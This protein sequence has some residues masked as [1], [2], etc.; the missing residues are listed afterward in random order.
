MA[1]EE[2]TITQIL[3]E[4]GI[5]L[6]VMADASHPDHLSQRQKLILALQEGE[7]TKKRVEAFKEAFPFAMDAFK[8]VASHASEAQ[9]QT[10]HR[11]H[12]VCGP[13]A[14][15]SLCSV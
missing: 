8:T 14:K 15:A 5:S 10:L 9:A 7:I 13:H 6:D 4:R 3:E 1:S 12:T 2:R 11:A